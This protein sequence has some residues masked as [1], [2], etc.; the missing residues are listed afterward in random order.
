MLLNSLNCMF[1][2]R[3]TEETNLKGDSYVILFF[4]LQVKISRVMKFNSAKIVSM[5]LIHVVRSS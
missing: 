3:N 5:I 2:K 4:R 1:C